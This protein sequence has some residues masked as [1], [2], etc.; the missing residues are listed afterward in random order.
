[1]PSDYFDM[2]ESVRDRDR[3]QKEHAQ[4]GYR[5]QAS[6]YSWSYAVAIALIAIV[7]A[8]MTI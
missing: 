1:M 5:R 3:L 7:A 6:A 8:I 4:I 2:T